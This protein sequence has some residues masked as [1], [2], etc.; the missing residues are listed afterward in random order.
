MILS[1][2]KYFFHAT[3]REVAEEF[4][5]PRQ[6]VQETRAQRLATAEQR[7]NQADALAAANLGV[8]DEDDDPLALPMPSAAQVTNQRKDHGDA[9]GDE[10]LMVWVH[11]QRQGQRTWPDMA[12]LAAEKGHHLSKDAL[13]SRYRRW[14]PQRHPPGTDTGG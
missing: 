9:P 2:L 3:P 4:G 10:A 5:L 14:L 1:L 13:R 12:Q 11:Q 7:A 6:A 8:E